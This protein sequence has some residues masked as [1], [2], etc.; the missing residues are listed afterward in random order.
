MLHVMGSQKQEGREA[1]RVYERA[2][3]GRTK[4]A[5]TSDFGLG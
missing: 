2:G 4:K 5:Y 3:R 1:G